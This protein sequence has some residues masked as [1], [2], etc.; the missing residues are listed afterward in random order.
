MP[1]NQLLAQ[2]LEVKYQAPVRRWLCPDCGFPLEE[3]EKGLHCKICT[4]RENAGIR[5][6]PRSPDTP[7]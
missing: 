2:Y 4:W 5:Y 1:F 6:I 7:R 3:T